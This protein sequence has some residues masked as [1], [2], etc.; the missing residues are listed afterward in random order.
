MK[1]ILSLVVLLLIAAPTIN[2]AELKLADILKA[3]GDGPDGKGNSADDTWQFWFEIAHARNS[4]V[5]LRIHTA[6]MPA[7]QLANGIPRRVRG[8]IGKFLPN[9]NMT[10]G[11]IYHRDWDGRFEGIWADKKA[12]AIMAHP[13]V[14]KSA[15]CAVAITYRVPKSGVYSVDGKLTDLQVKPAYPKHDGILWRI[16]VAS[17]GKRG[18]LIAKGGPIGDGKGR[19]DHGKFQANNVKV[20]KGELI[21]LVIHPNRWWGQDLTRI[22]SFRVTNLGAK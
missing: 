14:E 5:P 9:P 3:K 13:Y 2:A 1:H 22:D 17:A 18:R 21:R 16:E 4:F 6:T 19:P 11:W 20:Q 7:A 15:H 8:P 12:K 10:E